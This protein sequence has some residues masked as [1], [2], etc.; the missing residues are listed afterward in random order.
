MN[1]EEAWELLTE[2]TRNDSL[3]KHAL[4][5]EAAMR[6]YAR[7]WGEDEDYWGVTGLI[8][9]FD[10][11]RYPQPEDHPVKGAEILRGKGYPE[12]VVTA[13]LGHGDHTGVPRTTRL[14]QA[15]YA[16]DELA[17]MITAAALIRPDKSILALEASSVIKRMKDKAFARAVSREGIREGAEVL[18]IPLEEHIAA[19]IAAMREIAPALGLAGRQIP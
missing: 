2:Y 17:G 9:D 19:V 14:A 7:L 11:E 6:Y 5:V 13:I 16:V 15:L 4:S 1:R 18:G 8:H 10:Y 3:R 12:D